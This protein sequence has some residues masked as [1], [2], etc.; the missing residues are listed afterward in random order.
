MLEEHQNGEPCNCPQWGNALPHPPASP[1]VFR[2]TGPPRVPP[3][4]WQCNIG[5]YK[6]KTYKWIAEHDPLYGKW[7]VTVLRAPS[8]RNY[9]GG[10]LI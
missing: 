1:Q 3:E 8:A 2:A 6:G 4:E 9:L 10:L 7:L 5:K